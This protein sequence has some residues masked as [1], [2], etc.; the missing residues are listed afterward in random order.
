MKKLEST[1]R[2]R[3]KNAIRNVFLRSRERAAAIKREHNTCQRCGVKGSVAKGKEQKIVVH[4]R[5]GI[6]NWDKVIDVVYEEILCHPK[7]LDVLC[8]DCHKKGHEDD[9]S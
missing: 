1:P 5:S 9:F 4:H 6:G 2:S 8:P 3:I 7:Y